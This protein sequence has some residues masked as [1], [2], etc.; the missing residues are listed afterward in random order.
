LG[1]G[2]VPTTGRR[3]A[4]GGHDDDGKSTRILHAP[5]AH[6]SSLRRHL[7]AGH[8]VEVT[9]KEA[10]VAVVAHAHYYHTVPV[11]FTFERERER[12][13]QSHP[14]DCPLLTR[15]GWQCRCHFGWLARAIS[16]GGNQQARQSPTNRWVETASPTPQF[17]GV[18]RTLWPAAVGRP[19][20]LCSDG[21]TLPGSSM[22]AGQAIFSRS[23]LRWPTRQHH[24]HTTS[25]QYILHS[26][27]ARC[28][29]ALRPLR[30]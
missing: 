26:H 27:P 15:A 23:S 28:L 30:R 16:A 7:A 20:W 25:T 13:R 11:V 19:A 22:H 6:P 29:H 3:I 9:A 18:R 24:Q 4:R 2:H 12:E 14:Q 17:A 10:S 21:S 5:L 1:F 8:L